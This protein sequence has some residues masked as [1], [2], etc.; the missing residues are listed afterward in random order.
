MINKTIRY[1]VVFS[2]YLAVFCSVISGD[3]FASGNNSLYGDGDEDTVVKETP[4]DIYNQ[5]GAEEKA[6]INKFN[7]EIG[8]A[9]SDM[10][11]LE[12]QKRQEAIGRFALSGFSKTNQLVATWIILKNY[13]LGQDAIDYLFFHG[14]NTIKKLLL[15]KKLITSPYNLE[16]TFVQAVTKGDMNTIEWMVGNN[17]VPDK[18]GVN[19]A[20]M[21]ALFS[22]RPK[23]AVLDFLIKKNITVSKS[24]TK[25]LFR[26]GR[27]INPIQ[28]EWMLNNNIIPDQPTLEAAYRR[29]ASKGDRELMELLRPLVPQNV[30]NQ[31]R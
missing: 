24:F 26:D 7:T 1:S 25:L 29:A 13:K 6:I 4:D 28:L 11:S 3:L 27:N 30:A 15:N 2:L 22:L 10:D 16:I 17:M 8:D 14:D 19:A 12:E 5:M 9:K 31:Q 21:G 23:F 18:N 20:F